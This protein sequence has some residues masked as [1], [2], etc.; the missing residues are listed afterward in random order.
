MTSDTSTNQR[1]RQDTDRPSMSATENQQLG[2]H[3]LHAGQIHVSVTPQKVILI[4]GSCAG[5]C[6]WDPLSGVGGAAHYLLPSWD[7]RGM[8]SPRYGTVA[9]QKL[10]EQL[11]EAGAKRG[12]LQAKVF[13]GGCLFDSMRGSQARK[14]SLGERNVDTAIALLAKAHIPVVS[15]EVGK[16]RGQRIV[17]HTATGESHVAAL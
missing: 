1:L 9:I 11:I 15:A 14:D 12:Q 6:V 2:S 7:G 5:V 8:A 17:F 13:G 10:L 16:D 3:F 4:L